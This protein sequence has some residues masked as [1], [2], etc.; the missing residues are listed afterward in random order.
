MSGT[1]EIPATEE[2]GT[3]P[4]PAIGLTPATTKDSTLSTTTHVSGEMGDENLAAHDDSILRSPSDNSLQQSRRR[5][6]SSVSPVSPQHSIQPAPPSAN[7][8]RRSTKRRNSTSTSV[9]PRVLNGG[10]YPNIPTHTP[11][12]LPSASAQSPAVDNLQPYWMKQAGRESKTSSPGHSPPSSAAGGPGVPPLKLEPITEVPSP[13]VGRGTDQPPV[14]SIPVVIPALG[15]TSR[16]PSEVDLDPEVTSS[17]FKLTAELYKKISDTELA[18][19]DQTHFENPA[20]L[21]NDTRQALEALAKVYEEHKKTQGEKVTQLETEVAAMKERE[22]QKRGSMV[23]ME[24]QTLTE[25][26]RVVQEY[27]KTVEEQTELL[28][29]QSAELNLTEQ[30]TKRAEE[31]QQRLREK[32][33]R[34]LARLRS[35]FEKE[36]GKHSALEAELREKLRKMQEEQAKRTVH[37]PP[38]GVFT[39]AF[40]DIEDST[41]LW[42]WNGKVMKEV[43]KIHDTIIRQATIKY[44]GYEV[45][46]EGDSFQVAFHTPQ[47]AVMWCFEIQEKCMTA[48][49]PE[50]FMKE[51]EKAAVIKGDNGQ[52][53]WKGLRIRMGLHTGEALSEDIDPVTKRKFYKGPFVVE[54]GRMGDCGHGGQIILSR[55]TMDFL[56]DILVELGEPQIVNLGEYLLDGATRPMEIF[57]ISTKALSGRRHNDLRKAHKLTPGMYDAPSGPEVT[58]VFLFV[59][60]ATSLQEQFPSEF[61]AGVEM[62]QTLVRSLL[63]QHRGYECQQTATSGRFML[64][65]HNPLAAVRFCLA[66]QD[67]AMYIP[68]SP[69]LEVHDSCREI[70][71]PNG[72]MLFKGARMKM[73]VLTGKPDECKPHNVTGRLDYFGP[74]VNR[75]ARIAQKCEGG[76]ILMD[77][78]SYQ[79]IR[80]S[81]RS[82]GVPSIVDIGKHELK[83]VPQPEHLIEVTS[84]KLSGRCEIFRPQSD[85]SEARQLV[86]SGDSEQ[87]STSSMATLGQTERSV[88]NVMDTF[89][90][91]PPLDGHENDAEDEQG[92]PLDPEVRMS[93]YLAFMQEQSTKLGDLAARISQLHVEREQG[94]ASSRDRLTD[95]PPPGA[96]DTGARAR[97]AKGVRGLVTGEIATASAP[98]MTSGRATTQSPTPVVATRPTPGTSKAAS[99]QMST[100]TD[101]S[102]DSP[103]T[104]TSTK[105]GQDGT[106]APVSTLSAAAPVKKSS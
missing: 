14:G 63:K 49:W 81:Y 79:G 69:L 28:Q 80:S 59:D 91:V 85:P 44:F 33:D 3:P 42:E 74:I 18:T 21:V 57:E 25:S 54:S 29:K 19:P 93:Q 99:G 75:C 88:R 102:K 20:E 52:V 96:G 37:T 66:A 9:S 39:M 15:P 5:P 2:K 70:W 46:T 26:E 87:G 98:A 22:E 50:A 27:K 24:V 77:N 53:L 83:G 30:D 7:N 41:N 48:E 43:Q 71:G 8:G 64:S 6:A 51:V 72:T 106:A 32:Y 58:L 36:M 103:E 97:P 78:A 94:S 47:D 60:G 68:W 86:P 89:G 13:R 84:N 11:R 56:T 104:G 40:T 90:D 16:T 34:E 61:G 73:G 101:S 55:E 10:V 45:N 76:Q 12:R 92:V 95:T 67:A 1:G 62:W 65:F 4:L 35:A 82:L 31:A 100:V 38:T 17:L 23:S 105:A